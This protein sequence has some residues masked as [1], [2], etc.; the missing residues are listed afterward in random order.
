MF[1]NTT[2]T[3]L[4]YKDI[5]RSLKLEQITKDNQRQLQAKQHRSC[6]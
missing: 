2:Y 3:E 4:Y 1:D 6:K 5:D